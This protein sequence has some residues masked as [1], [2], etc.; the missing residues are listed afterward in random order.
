MSMRESIAIVIMAAKRIKITVDVWSAVEMVVDGRFF[1]C[2]VYKS[3]DTRPQ[4][5]NTDAVAKSRDLT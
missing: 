1:A 3:G 4:D 5:S 2:I